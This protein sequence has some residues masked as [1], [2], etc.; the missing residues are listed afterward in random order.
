M[1]VRKKIALAALLVALCGS[2]ATA[3]T[4]ATSDAAE[5]SVESHTEEPRTREHNIRQ[6][7]NALAK[8]GKK[9]P[10]GVEKMTDQEVF[11]AMFSELKKHVVPARM[12]TVL[13]D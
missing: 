7:E 3:V 11:D 5:V 10:A 6:W 1:T 2:S 9:L 13:V 12:P 4:F 8:S